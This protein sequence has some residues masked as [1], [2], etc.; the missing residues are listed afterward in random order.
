MS[1]I[2]VIGVSC[3][4]GS[5]LTQTEPFIEALR[6]LK[7]FI[8]GLDSKGIAIR[9][10]DLGGGVGITYRDEEP[11]HPRDYARAILDELGDTDL[12]LFLEPGRVLVGNGG[13]LVTRVEYTKM[14][15]GG[16]TAKRFVIVDAAMNDLARPSMY[17]AY[18]S[19]I[20]VKETTTPEYTVDIVGPI[21]E[22]GDFL[23]KDRLFPEVNQG[24]LLAVMS[25]GAY[26]FTMASNY[27][28][29]PRPP[30]ILVDG[31]NY[32]VIRERETY[33]DLIRG[34]HIPS[35]KG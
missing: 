31:D 6:K 28:S 21:C 12:T 7:T 2:E 9:N 10:L 34:E 13:I 23:A 8:K 19:I 20:P 17:G 33:Q 11:P 15:S 24:D 18:H 27:N 25:A 4:I 3:H 16:E 29:R 14:N 5:Q 35:R 22:S 32:T 1:H 30:E 26:G